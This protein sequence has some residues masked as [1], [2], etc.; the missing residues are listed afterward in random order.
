MIERVLYKAF[1]GL[2]SG[3][4]ICVLVILWSYISTRIKKKLGI[5]PDNSNSAEIGTPAEQTS[6]KKETHTNHTE[7]IFGEQLTLYEVF[8]SSSESSTNQYPKKKKSNIPLIVCV[9]LLMFSLAGNAYLFIQ[10]SDLSRKLHEMTINYYAKNSSERDLNAWKNATQE[11]YSFYHKYAV[12]VPVGTNTYHKYT[13]HSCDT[14]DFYIFNIENAKAQGYTA[15]GY[16]MPDVN[17]QR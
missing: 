14:S 17:C 8:P 7:D 15:C 3:A 1:V 10:N 9:V 4:M 16:C 5:T 12:I 11:E 2:I 6:L 13:C